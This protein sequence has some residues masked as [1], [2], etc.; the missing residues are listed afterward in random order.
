ME[1]TE[2]GRHTGEGSGTGHDQR[3]LARG[4]TVSRAR[5]QKVFVHQSVWEPSIKPALSEKTFRGEERSARRDVVKAAQEGE[6]I[7]AKRARPQL[8]NFVPDVDEGPAHDRLSM[9]GLG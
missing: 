4:D 3:R 9:G 7:E 5:P 1:R 8:A 2:F 6:I